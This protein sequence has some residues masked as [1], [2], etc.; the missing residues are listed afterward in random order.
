MQYIAN[1]LAFAR[2]AQIVPK[3]F[4]AR[5]VDR[6]RVRRVVR[7]GFRLRQAKWSGYD[8]V[9]RLRAPYDPA[10]PLAATLALLLDPGP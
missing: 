4:A 5:A 3:R 7:E 10:Q 8:C 1:G 6:N 2:L 9:F